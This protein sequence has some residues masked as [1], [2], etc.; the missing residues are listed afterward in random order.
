MITFIFGIILLLL[1]FG[2]PLKLLR[3]IGQGVTKLVIGA[4]FLFIL[5]TIGNGFGLHVPINIITSAIAGFLGIPG[6]FAL[7][8]IQLWIL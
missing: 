4:V 8:V 6:V 5:N 3:F 1:M 2:F 7:S